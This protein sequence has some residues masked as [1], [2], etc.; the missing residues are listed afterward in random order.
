MRFFVVLY[1]L[2][3]VN[4]KLCLGQSDGISPSDSLDI[5]L[6]FKPL[7]LYEEPQI[8]PAPDG[9][10]VLYPEGGWLSIYDEK[11]NFLR[12]IGGQTKI[13]R[14]TGSSCDSAK[15][16]GIA[17]S[18]EGCIFCYNPSYAFWYDWK[19]NRIKSN[20]YA[21]PWATEPDTA[22]A[23]LIGGIN[24]FKIAVGYFQPSDSTFYFPV[25]PRYINE[26]DAKI[27]KYFSIPLIG[28][29]VKNGKTWKLTRLLGERD[30]FYRKGLFPHLRDA[31]IAV[32]PNK[33][34]LYLLQEAS[35][36]IKVYSLTGSY[37]KTIGDNETL[38]QNL[39]LSKKQIKRN[40]D[41]PKV[42]EYDYLDARILATLFT[43]VYVEPQNGEIYRITR[44]PT[45][46][47]VPNT[48]LNIDTT[49]YG[50]NDLP[51]L[52]RLKRFARMK[53]KP[54][55]V[56]VFNPDGK[57]LAKF[58]PTTH[59]EV[60]KANDAHTVWV[61]GRYLPTQNIYRLYKY[62]LTNMIR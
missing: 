62:N 59:F 56:T 29:F 39:P 46:P 7:L 18:S 21:T 6:D 3:M 13:E 15:L 11:G 4:I 58:S 8:F 55:Q 17:L 32:L 24:S 1:L 37:L 30:D 26:Y 14:Q 16:T 41:P 43:Q 48:A 54:Y 31:N 50:A 38:P 23:F 34:A 42:D 36:Q 9:F 20:T 10:A 52:E 51:S 27:E 49:G 22:W 40:W 44:L 47:V 25:L 45:K 57:L 53:E 33:K 2:L 5:K 60:I 19:G 35:P 12:K 28:A 61:H